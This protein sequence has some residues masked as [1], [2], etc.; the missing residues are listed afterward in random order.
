MLRIPLHIREEI[1]KQ[2]EDGSNQAKIAR[3]LGVSRHAVQKIM[4]MHRVRIGLH[5]VE[6]G[7]KKKKLTMRDER[8]IARES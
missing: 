5:D 4:H 6:K 8:K 2:S 3:I 7:G 1:M